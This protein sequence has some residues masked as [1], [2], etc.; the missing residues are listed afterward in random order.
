MSRPKK[1]AAEI[2]AR[3]QPTAEQLELIPALID[4]GASVRDIMRHPQIRRGHRTIARWL[5]LANR[6]LPGSGRHLARAAGA[7]EKIV[8]QMV[9]LHGEGYSMRAISEMATIRLSENT[10][11]MWLKKA[12][13]DT[14]VR[15][16]PH[17]RQV[18]LIKE[19]HEE[20]QS[21]NE[22]MRAVGTTSSTLARWLKDMKLPL[23]KK[24]SPLA[25][26]PRVP[27]RPPKK[28]AWGDKEAGSFGKE[29]APLPKDPNHKSIA[30]KTRESVVAP[31]SDN[32]KI[33]Y[34]ERIPPERR[35]SFSEIMAAK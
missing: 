9:I 21:F 32:Y 17:P 8:A 22:I 12:G 34:R 24:K 31:T 18:D 13:I 30:Q 5:R 15:K 4:Q 28:P 29:K 33:V 10:V 26:K 35:M 11:R 27:R 7:K 19:L 6:E 16:K 23:P 14:G 20:G 3:Q 25:V 1:S 2:L